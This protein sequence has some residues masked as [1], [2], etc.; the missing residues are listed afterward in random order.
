MSQNMSPEIWIPESY[1]FGWIRKAF[2]CLWQSCSYFFRQT[3]MSQG[4]WNIPWRDAINCWSI[5]QF[6]GPK[7]RGAVAASNPFSD[8]SLGISPH[9]AWGSCNFAWIHFQTPDSKKSL[10]NGPK[11]KFPKQSLLQGF[12]Q[13]IFCIRY[14]LLAFFLTLRPWNLVRR[15]GRQ[16][17]SRRSHLR[18]N[19]RS[20]HFRSKKHMWQHKFRLQLVSCLLGAS[21]VLPGSLLSAPG[22]L[23]GVYCTRIHF[24]PFNKRTRLLVQE[25]YMSSCSRRIHVFLLSGKTCLFVQ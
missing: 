2:S 22:W 21:W 17:W 9:G 10:K 19:T 13:C 15:R 23:L 1:I 12:W 24:F 14:Y 4:F 6:H 25:E 7:G 16:C 8:I 18:E 3:Y 20:H 5:L 11:W